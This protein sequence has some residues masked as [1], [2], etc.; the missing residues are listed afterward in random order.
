ML[1]EMA[2]SQGYTHAIEASIYI[3]GAITYTGYACGFDLNECIEKL[4]ECEPHLIEDD[5]SNITIVEE[6]RS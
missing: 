6:Y 2:D 1:K 4:K 3:S 5:L